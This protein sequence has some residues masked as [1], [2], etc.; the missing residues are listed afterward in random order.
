MSRHADHTADR[1]TSACLYLAAAHAR[2][3]HYRKNVVE[4]GH[5]WRGTGV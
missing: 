1:A 2:Q 3:H 4:L 5:L